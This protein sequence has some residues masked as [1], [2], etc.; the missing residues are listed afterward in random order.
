MAQKY[1]WA[2][3]E[4]YDRRFR[5]QVEG[6]DTREWADTDPGLFA[7]YVSAFALEKQPKGEASRRGPVEVQGG[8]GSGG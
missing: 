8:F 5:E 1:E 7:E 3:C 2:A 6:D 4:E